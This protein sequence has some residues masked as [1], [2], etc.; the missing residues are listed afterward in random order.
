MRCG[1]CFAGGGSYSGERDYMSAETAKKAVDFLTEHSGN[2]KSLEIDFFGGEP[3]LN[4]SAVQ[5]TVAYARSREKACGKQFKFTL[6]TNALLLT[7]EINDFL[8]READNVVLSLDGRRAVNDCVRKA[9]G[10]GGTYDTVAKRALAFKKSRGEKS[11]YARGTYTAKNLD[12][13]E[14]V[15][16]LSDLG[17]DQISVEPAVL[18]QSH[19]LAIRREHLPALKKEYRKLAAHYIERRR[20]EK[21]FNFFHFLLDL[22][23]GP[24]LKKRITGCGAGDEYLAVAPTGELYPCHRFVGLKEYRIGS[25]YGGAPDQAVRAPF[26]A[27]SLLTKDSCKECFAKYFC[28]GGCAANNILYE[29]EIDKPYGISCEL[30]KTRFECALGIYAAEKQSAA[31]YFPQE[32]RNG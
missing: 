19:P 25:V 23:N 32:E 26:I 15:L 1:Y 27:S 20:G 18:P 11:Y 8:N 14:D 4:L 7:D 21:S 5:E 17:F 12:F 22:E 29:G 3:L 6:T 31:E 10:G 24:C 13:C 9:V 30:L 16:H 2:R 28:G